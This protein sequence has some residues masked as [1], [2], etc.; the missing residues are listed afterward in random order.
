MAPPDF[1]AVQVNCDAVIE[2]DAQGQIRESCQRGGLECFA[3][4]TGGEFCSGI[5]ISDHSLLVALPVAKLGRAFGPIRIRE[6]RLAP[7]GAKVG[8]PIIITPLLSGLDENA[9]L[10]RDA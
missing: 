10:R 1:G 5:T 3:K 7:R 4:I 2:A 6:V 9:W 8:A